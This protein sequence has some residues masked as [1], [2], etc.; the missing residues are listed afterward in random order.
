M[1]CFLIDCDCIL[2][3]TNGTDG[4]MFFACRN[5]FLTFEKINF[6]SSPSINAELQQPIF[7]II[8]VPKT[9]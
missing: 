6:F 9:T 7:Q 1:I 3:E 5:V 4:W 8:S 2:R